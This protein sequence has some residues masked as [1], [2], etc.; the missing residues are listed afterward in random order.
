[1]TWPFPRSPATDLPRAVPPLPRAALLEPSGPC[2]HNPPERARLSASTPTVCGQG[3]TS[4]SIQHY[5]QQERVQPFKQV[6]PELSRGSRQIF[7]LKKSELTCTEHGVWAFT[8]APRSAPI[9][10]ARIK[11]RA[12]KAASAGMGRWP[13][14]QVPND[15]PPALHTAQPHFHMAP[16]SRSQ[17]S[18][19]T[20]RGPN[21]KEPTSTYPSLPYVC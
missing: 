20:Q 10:L 8:R 15:T 17:P 19:H 6:T 5:H 12:G 14:P 1:M 16:V 2:L 4:C 11:Y 18:L 7:L 3:W 13:D 9:S 21:T